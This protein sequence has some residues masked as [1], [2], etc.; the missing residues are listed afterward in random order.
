MPK[1][2]KVTNTDVMPHT[3]NGVKINPGKTEYIGEYNAKTVNLA[4]AIRMSGLIVNIAD[5]PVNEVIHEV[6]PVKKD[7]SESQNT[8]IKEEPIKADSK[9]EEKSKTVDE[10]KNVVTKNTN[11]KQ[12]KSN[13]KDKQFTV[14][15]T[16]PTENNKKENKVS[17]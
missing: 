16:K 13:D 4:T 5:K 10:S 9:K 11:T 7:S 3:Y 6:K 15:K 14:N 12:S 2:I 17:E 1:Y 8:I